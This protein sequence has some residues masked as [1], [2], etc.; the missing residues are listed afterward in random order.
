MNYKE[1]TKKELLE[2]LELVRQKY[3]EYLK[4]GLNLDMSRGKPSD[5]QLDLSNDILKIDT[6]K[7]KDG[8]DARNYGILDGIE[9]AKELFSDILD[10]PKE[11]ILIGGNST[12]NMLYDC[13]ARL[14]MF[15]DGENKP[16]HKYDKI[17]IL[18]LV[19]GYDRHFDIMEEFGFEM[20]NINLTKDGFDIEKVRSLCKDDDS[21]KGIICVPV[22][23]NP[24]GV[25]FSKKALENLASLETKAK[26][27]KIFYD[28]AYAIHHIYENIEIDNIFKLCKKYDTLDRLLYFFSTSKITFAGG[29]ISMLCGSD[30][31]IEYTKRH[32]S[33]QTIGYDKIAQLKTVLFLKNKNNTIEHMKKHANIL[34]PKFDI[35]FSKLEENFKDNAI[36]S[37]ENPKGGYFVSVN[38]EKNLAKEVVRLCKGCGL[39]LT[40]A[41]STYPYKKDENN[42]NIR[43]APS[44]PPLD[45]LQTAM[46]IF[47]ICVRLATL[48]KMTA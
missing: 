44:Y 36:L 29:G 37:W 22:H 2:E 24:T 38:T 26:D 27:F 34:K 33:K 23:S 30:K 21:V 15:G 9:E 12:L 7:T 5:E 31:T 17:K 13:I 48:E 25:C 43:I 6:F 39:I 32:L 4:C 11:N 10:L 28:N 46:D 19:P 35:V 1:M 16:W 47:C 45:E 20:I 14:Y 18:C 8:K 42:S 3:K 41:G 40:N